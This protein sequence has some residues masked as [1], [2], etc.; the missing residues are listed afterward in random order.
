MGLKIN[1]AVEDIINPGIR[2][3][4]R[5]PKYSVKQQVGI[6]ACELFVA[7]TGIRW[8]NDLVWVG[9]GRQLRREALC[10]ERAPHADHA[11]GV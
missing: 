8:A 10:E 1:Y 9:G 5:D 4:Y 11:C 7:R 6:D 2:S 3:A